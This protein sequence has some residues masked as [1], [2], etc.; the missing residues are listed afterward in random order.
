MKDDVGSFAIGQG[1]KQGVVLIDENPIGRIGQRLA[2]KSH[3]RKRAVGL[4]RT[5]L[6]HGF[7]RKE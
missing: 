3:L 2:R 4:A 1:R 6:R 5:G 7:G